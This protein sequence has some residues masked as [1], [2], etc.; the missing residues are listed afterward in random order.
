[1]MG[2]VKLENSLLDHFERSLDMFRSAILNFPEDEWK[3]GD[4]DYL[5]P[6]G[7]A[8]HVVETMHFYS[9]DTPVD[10]FEW[11]GRFGCDWEDPDSVK[12]PTQEQV[13]KYLDEV[14]G[15]AGNIISN[16]DPLSEE[17]SYPWTGKILHSRFLYL[18]RHIQH[19]TAEMSLELKRRG[20]TCPD[21]K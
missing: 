17:K 12:L 18:L 20:Y 11:G 10:S 8:Y 4:M 2:K 5:R 15:I 9:S 16:I 14:W 13:L 3:K 1:M 6:V 19:H 7:V 21:W